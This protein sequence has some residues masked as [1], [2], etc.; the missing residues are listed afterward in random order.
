MIV[1][2]DKRIVATL[3]VLAA[4]TLAGCASDPGTTADSESTGHKIYKVVGQ[5]LVTP[6]NG[7]GL[8]KV[9]N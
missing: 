7:D 6:Q 5:M 1:A 8:T 9:V 3:V 2:L 4:N